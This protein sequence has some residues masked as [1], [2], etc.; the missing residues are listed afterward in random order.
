MRVCS[1]R[2][3]VLFVRRRVSRTMNCNYIQVGA[4][5]LHSSTIVQMVQTIELCRSPA[6]RKVKRDSRV[7][8]TSN[9]W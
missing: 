8:R 4:N 7:S 5:R 9:E 1:W 2:R 6:N 3:D